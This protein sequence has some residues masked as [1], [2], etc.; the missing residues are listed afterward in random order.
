MANF[1]RHAEARALRSERAKMG[2][3]KRKGT[4][5]KTVTGVHGDTVESPIRPAA[6]PIKAD[7]VQH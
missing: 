4:P 1:Q 7:P 6:N 2:H 5:L 3:A